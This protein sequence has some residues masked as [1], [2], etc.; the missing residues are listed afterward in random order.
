MK[1]EGR[2]SAGQPQLPITLEYII[3]EIKRRASPKAVAGMARFGIQTGTAFGVSIPQLRDLAKRAETS[4]IR[5]NLQTEKQTNGPSEKRSSLREQALS[6][7]PNWLFITK[8][9]RTKR[10]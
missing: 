1:I 7:W 4:S 2:T 3:D 8:R 5:H 9:L 6:L 10:F